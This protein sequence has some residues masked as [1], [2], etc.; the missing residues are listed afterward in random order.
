[1]KNFFCFLLSILV[2]AILVAFGMWIAYVIGESSLPF[3]VKL[4]LLSK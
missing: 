3:W 1:M 4:W 2:S